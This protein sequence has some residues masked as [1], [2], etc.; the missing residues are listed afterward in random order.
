M[1]SLAKTTL[2]VLLVGIDEDDMTPDEISSAPTEDMPPLEGE[3]DDTSRME[4]V[5]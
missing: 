1:V 4:E 3:D 2:L 5:D